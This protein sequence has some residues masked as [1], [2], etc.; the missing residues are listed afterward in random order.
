MLK[1]Y[2]ERLSNAPLSYHTSTPRVNSLDHSG[3]VKVSLHVSSV[4]SRDLSPDLARELLRTDEASR[5][6]GGRA[7]LRDD[8]RA[9]LEQ[10]VAA[11]PPPAVTLYFDGACVPC[12][13]QSG[14]LCLSR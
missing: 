11:E 5:A 13:G 1:G 6:A 12:G 14:R 2:R 4:A 3:T 8:Q 9:E 7:L 10:L